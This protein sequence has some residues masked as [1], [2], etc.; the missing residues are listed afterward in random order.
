MISGAM[1]ESK[2]NKVLVIT[3]R[4]IDDFDSSVFESFISSAIATLKL[5]PSLMIRV[6]DS[7]V[8]LDVSY[9]SKI[10]CREEEKEEHWSSSERGRFARKRFNHRPHPL[11]L[12]WLSHSRGFSAG[13]A[14]STA[15]RVTSAP[16]VS[17]SSRGSTPLFFDFYDD[18]D[19]DDN[20]VCGVVVRA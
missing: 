5:L 3:R 13:A 7:I 20:H 9:A 10:S 6:T 19:D 15:R 4:P 2:S 14:K 8:S 11:T 1:G 12:L 18:E 17:T 16:C